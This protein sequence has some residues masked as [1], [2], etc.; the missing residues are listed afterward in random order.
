M[1]RIECCCCRPCSRLTT[2]SLSGRG[3]TTIEHLPLLPE[4]VEAHVAL[5]DDAVLGGV[6]LRLAAA[7][8]AVGA[9]HLCTRH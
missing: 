5:R 8:E 6:C 2:P 9:V 4:L 7:G 1:L 3:A